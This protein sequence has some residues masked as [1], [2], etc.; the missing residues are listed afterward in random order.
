MS[1]R[2]DSAMRML[3]MPALR[4][5]GRLSTKEER[6]IFASLLD[7]GDRYAG[8]AGAAL[9]LLAH[10]QCGVKVAAA[11]GSARTVLG[12]MRGAAVQA[13]QTLGARISYP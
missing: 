9:A 11:F 1:A 2:R 12:C 7:G 5:W 6:R 3:K 4:F 13:C 10:V 8:G